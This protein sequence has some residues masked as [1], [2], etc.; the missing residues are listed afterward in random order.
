MAF[1]V[2][3]SGGW[4][5]RPRKE[6]LGGAGVVGLRAEDEGSAGQGDAVVVGL[7]GLVAV[8]DAYGHG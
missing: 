5:S 7:D 6:A 2:V 1:A 8:A 4:G 3:A